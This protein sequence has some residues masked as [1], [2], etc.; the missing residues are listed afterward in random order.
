MKFQLL[1]VVTRQEFY[2]DHFHRFLQPKGTSWRFSFRTDNVWW[3]LHQIQSVSRH[4]LAIMTMAECLSCRERI[5]NMRRSTMDLAVST[6]SIQTLPPLTFH[7]DKSVGS[8]NVKTQIRPFPA[9]GNI[10]RTLIITATERSISLSRWRLYQVPDISVGDLIV[11]L[12]CFWD[13]WV[14]R[15]Y[16]GFIIN[17]WEPLRCG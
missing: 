8:V 17:T 7:A 13:W 14:K 4:N 3:R 15:L 11:W 6:R 9:H 1:N 12:N 5:P 10:P 2:F 16:S